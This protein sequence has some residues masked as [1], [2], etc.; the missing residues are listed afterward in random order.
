[1]TKFLFYILLSFFPLTGFSQNGHRF[2]PASDD[3]I[4]YMGRVA[5]SGK[6]VARYDWPGIQV[7]FRFTGEELKL[8]FAGGERNYFDLFIDDK[9]VNTL[10]AKDDTI[11]AVNSIKGNGPHSARFVKRTEGGMGETRFYGV[12]LSKKGRLLPWTKEAS[13]HI[14]FIGN[15]ITCGYG[16]ESAS[17]NDNFDP[18]TE[19]VG[20]SYATLVAKAF[21]ADYHVVAHSGLGVV[22][23]YGD[24]E[25][26]STNFATMPQRFSRTLDLDDSLSWNYSL[27]QANAVVINLG[28]NDFSTT[29]HP[30]KV[31][32]QR[33]YEKLIQQVRLAYGTIPVFCI[34]GPMIDEPCYSYVKE[35]VHSFGIL[36]G[37]YNVFFIGIP[38]A[39][40]NSKE[41]LGADSHPSDE[42]QQKMASHIIPVIA[43]VTG[44]DF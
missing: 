35:V 17:R 1:M 38:S 18:R 27:W 28:T 5:F 22:R 32:F 25:K 4:N 44:W 39:L 42:G 6:D 14:E 7:R 13:R 11:A 20:K 23:N 34:V 33:E 30:D 8:R 10:H 21:G 40:L 41:D 2:F 31:I 3:H 12:E 19:N 36:Y 37:D 15:S 16:V 29:P 24:P 43:T 9:L 26:V